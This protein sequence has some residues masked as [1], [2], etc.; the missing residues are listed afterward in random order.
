MYLDNMLLNE[1]KCTAFMGKTSYLS[2]FF[3]FLYRLSS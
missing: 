2:T 1:V 3:S